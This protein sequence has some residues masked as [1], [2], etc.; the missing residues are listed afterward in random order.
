MLISTF[1]R[2]QQATITV[3]PSDTDTVIIVKYSGQHKSQ[4]YGITSAARLA[5]DAPRTVDIS[6][7]KKEKA[8]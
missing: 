2:D 7:Q 5:F 1:Q 4:F 8:A 3:P 6:F